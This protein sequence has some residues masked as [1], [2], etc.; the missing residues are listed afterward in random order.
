MRTVGT[1]PSLFRTSRGEG[2][3]WRHQPRETWALK[4]LRPWPLSRASRALDAIISG[5]NGQMQQLTINPLLN[6]RWG[7][8]GGSKRYRRPQMQCRRPLRATYSSSRHVKKNPR[9]NR[10][11]WPLR[12]S[13]RGKPEAVLRSPADH[14]RCLRSSSGPVVGIS[15][16]IFPI[17]AA[18]IGD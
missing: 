10:Y 1:P 4:C 17:V 13:P 14:L 8:R 6:R 3:D 2:N 11:G 7:R 18:I 5:K 15:Q 16:R 9:H 12:G